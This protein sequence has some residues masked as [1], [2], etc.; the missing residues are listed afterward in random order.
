MAANFLDDVMAFLEGLAQLRGDEACR[1]HGLSEQ[2]AAGLSS[3][4]VYH[5][6][7]GLFGFNNSDATFPYRCPLTGTHDHAACLRNFAGR[8]AAFFFGEH[9]TRR[10]LFAYDRGFDEVTP[11]RTL[12]PGNTVTS[13]AGLK[14]VIPFGHLRLRMSGPTAGRL[15]AAEIRDRFASANLPHLH[16]RTNV[17]DLGDAFRPGVELAATGTRHAIDLTNE[18]E[19]Q[20]FGDLMLFTTEALVTGADI[21]K[22]FEPDCVL[23]IME[24]KEQEL[25]ALYQQKHAAILKKNR[26]LHDLVF[27]AGHWW[28]DAADLAAA[29]RQVQAFID[30]VRHNFGERSPAWRQIRSAEHRARRRQQLV[31]ALMNYRTER[32]AWDRLFD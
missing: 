1:F 20:F 25:L 5:D 30:N 10:T 13:Y 2:L 16:R 7:A 23:R 31:E 21:G 26:Q 28:L 15:I 27:S 17:A 12:Y 14:Y 19:R 3:G 11:A 6:M 18:F 9:L 4:A 29:L 32:A 8:L 22:P 24:Q